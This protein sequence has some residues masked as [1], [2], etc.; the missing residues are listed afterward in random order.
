MHSYRNE[1]YQIGFLAYL[2]GL[3]APTWFALRRSIESVDRLIFALDKDMYAHYACKHEI[4]RSL[5]RT[6]DAGA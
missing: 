2:I 1:A 5:L 4:I 3:M 6:M